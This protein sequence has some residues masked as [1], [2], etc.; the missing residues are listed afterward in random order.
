MQNFEKEIQALKLKNK[1]LLK[2]IEWER[3]IFKRILVI[4]SVLLSVIAFT[5]IEGSIINKIGFVLFATVIITALYFIF[6]FVGVR[7]WKKYKS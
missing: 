4:L 5:F 1:H 7:I 3:S 2:E 6:N